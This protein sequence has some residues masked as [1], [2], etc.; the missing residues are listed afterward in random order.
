MSG[1]DSAEFSG[2]PG[3]VCIVG[4]GPAGLA[5]ARACKAAGIAFEVF[6]RH[7][8]PGGIW[9]IENPGTPMYETAH[10]ISSKTLSGFVDFAMPADYPDYPSHRQV[11]AY[12]KDFA[13][14]HGLT[15]HIAFGTAV[16]RAEPDTGVGWQVRLSSGETRRFRALVCAS[17]MTW[18]PALPGY[19]GAFTGELRHSVTYRGPEEFRGKRVLVVGGGNSG[20]D[21][22]CDAAGHAEAA[23]LSLRRGYHFIPKHIFGVPADVFGASGPP[24]PLAL[25]QRVFQAL[26]RL[27]TGDL[28][29]LGL[30]KPD[31][32]LFESH[33]ILNSLVLHHLSH[34]DLTAKPDVKELR[35]GTVVFQDGSEAEVDLIICATG[36]DWVIPY[37]DRGHFDWEGSRLKSYLSAFTR[38]DD[39]FTLGFLNTNAGVYG[40]FDR[41]AH[42]VTQFLLDQA[43]D[44]ARAA[45]FR[46]KIDGPR[47][48]LGG[49]IRFVGSPRH[50]SYLHHPA[51]QRY[52]ETLRKEMGWP[53][54]EAGAFEALRAAAT[55]GGGADGE[56][57]AAGKAA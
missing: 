36:Y 37:V 46:Q 54:L 45:R 10:F 50:A 7:N 34:G 8:G 30:P 35:G 21:I 32:R 55:G 16:E 14:A 5:Q 52:V 15:R 51:F 38:R 11:L 3:A 12:L 20:C 22:A 48:D 26:L 9:D 44:P 23:W 2:G 13:R 57:A 25:Q 40:D 4:A 49:G 28:R 1:G 29:R 53:A 42:M 47:P 24:L 39:L 43:R 17:G 31:H 6:E 56:A 27:L 19:P 41:L 33:P 18:H